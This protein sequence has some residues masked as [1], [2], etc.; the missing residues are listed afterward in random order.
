MK[1]AAT[2]KRFANRMAEVQTLNFCPAILRMCKGSTLRIL[3]PHYLKDIGRT[4][5]ATV[6]KN[7]T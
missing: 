3:I 6:I 4:L 5:M 1:I 2:N 7:K